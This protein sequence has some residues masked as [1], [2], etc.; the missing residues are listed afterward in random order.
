MPPEPA[1]SSAPAAT[2]EIADDIL[3]YKIAWDVPGGAV[4]LRFT[5]PDAPARLADIVPL[6]RQLATQVACQTVARRAKQARPISCRKGCAACCEYFVPVS[7]PEALRL[8]VEI[9]QMPPRL[10]ACLRQRFADAAV[11]LAACARR[12]APPG[13]TPRMDRLSEMY[14]DLHAPCPLLHNGLCAHYA[15]RPVACREHITAASPAACSRP[16]GAE[17]VQLP[18]SLL[19]GLLRLTAELTGA[20]AEVLGLGQSLAWAQRRPQLHERTWPSRMIFGRFL[21]ILDQLATSSAARV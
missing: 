14:A 3:T 13:E 18:V 7:P 2:G 5:V 12:T 11:R 17:P 16:G 1:Q 9:D 8:A 15:C 6:A 10:G 19:E 20:E 4:N 21:Q